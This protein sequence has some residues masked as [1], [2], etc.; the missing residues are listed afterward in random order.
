[1]FYRDAVVLGFEY[2]ETFQ[3]NKERSIWVE[4]RKHER[5][6]CVQEA[7]K[8]ILQGHRSGERKERV[9]DAGDEEYV[10]VT[11]AVVLPSKCELGLLGN[12]GHW[13]CL[14]E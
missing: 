14:N 11:S 7:L 10:W 5:A 6:G 3:K 12:G 13:R 2:R 9:G 8:S 4:A 1:M